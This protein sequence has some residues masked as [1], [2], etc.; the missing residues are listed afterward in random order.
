MNAMENSSLRG[1]CFL[2][3]V[4]E[5]FLWQYGRDGKGFMAA[6][7]EKSDR[8]VLEKSVYLLTYWPTDS[9]DFIGCLFA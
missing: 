6:I 9:G 1:T 4:I 5:R 2:W 7:S 8:A 3:T